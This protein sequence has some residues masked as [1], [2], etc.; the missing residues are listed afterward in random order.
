M[1]LIRPLLSLISLQT[2]PWTVLFEFLN[3]WHLSRAPAWNTYWTK[4]HPTGILDFI[5]LFAPLRIFWSALDLSWIYFSWLVLM[6][7]MSLMNEMPFSKLSQIYTWRFC[8]ALSTEDFY[9]FVFFYWMN[10]KWWCFGFGLVESIILFKYFRRLYG[11]LLGILNFSFEFNVL[12]LLRADVFIRCQSCSFQ[13][14]WMLLILST[15]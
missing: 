7:L 1:S 10:V 6:R 14:C 8:C 3:F 11:F 12:I 13:C 2:L 4:T 5:L 15:L 9:A